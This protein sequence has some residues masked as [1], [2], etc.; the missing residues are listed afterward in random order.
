[1]GR[2]LIIPVAHDFICPWCWVGLF[3]VKRLKEQF[4]VEIEWRGHEL[5]PEELDWPEPKPAMPEPPNKPPILSRFEFL[6]LM[7]RI[8]VPKIERPKRMRIHAALEAVEYF[9]EFAP[10]QVDDFVETLYRAYWERGE[11][12]GDIDVLAGIADQFKIA[13]PEVPIRKALEEKRYRDKIVSFDAPSYRTGVYNVPTFFIGE[14]RLAE[15]P[16]EVLERAMT[17]HL[18]TLPNTPIPQYPSN[19]PY[20]A[21]QFPP[22]S[23]TR[24]YTYINMVA[25][26][27]GKIILGGRDEPVVDLGSQNDHQLMKRIEAASDAVLLGAQTLRAAKKSW[28]PACR[29]RIVL[30]HS[31]KLPFDSCFFTEDAIVASKDPVAT[32]DGVQ[33]LIAPDL[34]HLLS[35]LRNQGVEKLLVLGGS[36]LNAELFEQGMIDEIFLTIAPK[37]KL[38]EDVPTI[39]DGNALPRESIQN[40]SIVEQHQ[41]GE[42]LF[43]R[44]RRNP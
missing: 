13:N 38:G 37:I 21:L 14:K 34:A 22:A 42:E 44:Y 1:M 17:E 8:D 2:P 16:Y 4:G 35:E 24:P 6:K 25:T 23:K 3:Q 31:G 29:K 28:N 32:P 5:M 19:L 40:Y 7:D 20:A 12:I 27:D 41:I 43:L 39:A 33:A 26:I 9:K 36:T 10:T 15:M 11:T 18:A 30:T